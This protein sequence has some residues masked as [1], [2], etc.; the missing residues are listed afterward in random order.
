MFP[1]DDLTDCRIQ[2]LVWS[3]GIYIF[4]IYFLCIP[5]PQ[6]V[7]KTSGIDAQTGSKSSRTFPLKI[8]RIGENLIDGF[9]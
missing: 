4:K 6:P 1:A 3:I 2:V 7:L 9:L 5:Y 8:F